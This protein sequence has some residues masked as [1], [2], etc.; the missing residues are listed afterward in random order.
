MQELQRELT[1][2]GVV[3]LLINCTSGF[4]NQAPAAAKKI[5]ARENMAITDWIIDDGFQIRRTYAMRTAPHMFVIDKNGV[6]A[7][8]G[9][10]DD[11]PATDGDPRT[12]RNYVREA[13]RALLAGKEVP[14]SQTKPYGCVLLYSGMPDE[15]LFRPP[16]SL[17]RR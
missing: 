14:V 16:N 6:L 9:A 3:W 2:N 15:Q 4:Q 5:W 13:V 10:I 12:A 17:L 11:R 1:T 8:Q 7:Y